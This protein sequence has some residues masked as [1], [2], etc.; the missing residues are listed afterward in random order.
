MA[1]CRV[2]SEDSP[3]STSSASATM[4]GAPPMAAGADRETPVSAKAVRGNTDTEVGPEI[5][6]SRPVRAFT[7]CTSWS[8]TK[9]NGVMTTRKVAAAT[10]AHTTSSAT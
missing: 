8:R 4:V 3:I 9:S 6:R 2:R 10:P 7:C 1:A 5:T